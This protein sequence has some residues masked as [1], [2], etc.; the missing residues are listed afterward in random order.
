VQSVFGVDLYDL[1]LTAAKQA[2]AGA[3]A[4][5]RPASCRIRDRCG[6]VCLCGGMCRV[7][8][9]GQG[10]GKFGPLPMVV[11][12]ASY[13]GAK[14]CA[15]LARVVTL[16]WITFPS[17]S[18]AGCIAVVQQAHPSTATDHEQHRVRA[19]V[20]AGGVSSCGGCG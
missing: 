16:L 18:R 14:V 6:D 5:R 2:A 15:R 7:C 13:H 17:D 12:K 1:L 20:G 8:T 9:G 10:A 4:V 19:R 3:V 11:G